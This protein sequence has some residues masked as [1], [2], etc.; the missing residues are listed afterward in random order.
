MGMYAATKHALAAISD[1]L[2]IELASD[3]IGVTTI[4]PGLTE[5]A[6]TENMLQ[7]VEAPQIPPVVRFA[8]AETVARRIYQGIRW[9]IRDVYVAPEDI[10]AVLSDAVIPAV[11]DRIM[12]FFVRAG[13]HRDVTFRRVMREREGSSETADS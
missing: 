2:R 13:A 5:T 1:A 8:P 10:A 7:E 3:R 11:S 6:F 12:R 4:Y 9:N